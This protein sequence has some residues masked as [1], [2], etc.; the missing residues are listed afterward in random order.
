MKEQEDRFRN[1]KEYVR[2]N[3]FPYW[4][5][6]SSK[7]QLAFTDKK[8]GIV[9]KIC[10]DL[11]GRKESQVYWWDMNKKAILSVLKRKRNDVAAYLTE[12]K[13][14]P[15]KIPNGTLNTFG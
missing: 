11:H 13:A 6:F 15:Y 8:G 4:K 9:L 10:N 5:I 3:L 7:K 14:P 2:S 1:L 12:I